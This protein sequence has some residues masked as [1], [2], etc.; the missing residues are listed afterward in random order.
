MHHTTGMISRL[1]NVEPVS[2]SSVASIAS[3]LAAPNENGLARNQYQHLFGTT[4]VIGGT[5]L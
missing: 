1:E 5:E 3:D 4:A 2:N